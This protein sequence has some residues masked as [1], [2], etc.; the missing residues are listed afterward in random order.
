MQLD[1]SLCVVYS[2]YRYLVGQ[3]A[4]R[5]K[6]HAAGVEW[7]GIVITGNRRERI[8]STRVNGQHGVELAANGIKRVRA[9]G[10]RRPAI[11]NRAIPCYRRMSWFI[12]LPSGSARASARGS[13]HSSDDHAILQIIVPGRVQ[14]QNQISHLAPVSIQ[15]GR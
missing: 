5:L 9:I 15:I 3:V 8:R 4:L 6:Q 2:I 7:A 13:V 12:T 1:S 10:G 14:V 11:P